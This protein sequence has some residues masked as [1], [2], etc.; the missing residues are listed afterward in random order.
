MVDGHG[1][2]RR[3]DDVRVGE[4]RQPDAVADF[5]Y[6]VVIEH[7]TSPQRGDLRVVRL[8]AIRPTGPGEFTRSLCGYTPTEGEMRP[9][10][11]WDTV[12]ANIRCASCSAELRSQAPSDSA[13]DLTSA[14]P[15]HGWGQTRRSL[16]LG[17]QRVDIQDVTVEDC[18]ASGDDVRPGGMPPPVGLDERVAAFV[19]IVDHWRSA[20]VDRATDATKGAAPPS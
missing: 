17:P 11:S 20:D 4:R 2:P 5:S 13:I 15:R 19:E 10:R 3:A 18:P 9:D 12:T 7:R 1:Y 16:Q 14:Q 8:H 6:G